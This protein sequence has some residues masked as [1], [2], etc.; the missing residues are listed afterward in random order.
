MTTA[1]AT[2]FSSVAPTTSSLPSPTLKTLGF[3]TVFL[4]SKTSFKSLHA[5]VFPSNVTSVSAMGARMVASPTITKSPLSLDFE[6]SVFKK[7]KVNLADHEE[8]IVRGGR[9]LFHLLPDAFKGIKQI[10]VIGWGSQG[11]A[12]TQNLK[13]S[14]AEA[15]SDIVVKMIITTRA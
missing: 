12:Q 10:G 14:L 7:E 15:K 5:R 1:A 9:D 4:S 8:Y 6:T 3:T 2:T 11:P 13:D